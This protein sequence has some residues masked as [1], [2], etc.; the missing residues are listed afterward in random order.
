MHLGPP[1][2]LNPH[3][4]GP[5]QHTNFPPPPSRIPMLGAFNPENPGVDYIPAAPFTPLPPSHQQTP[6]PAMNPPRPGDMPP[7]PPIGNFDPANPDVRY[8]PAASFTPLTSPSEHMPANPPWNMQNT[9]FQASPGPPKGGGF[10]PANPSGGPVLSAWEAAGAALG[11]SSYPA[12][13]M[14]LEQWPPMN[15][16]WVKA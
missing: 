15:G 9:G 10:N 13:E 5:L 14:N 16:T 6:R 12:G 1:P 2:V 7:T 8:T 11:G 3:L 4:A